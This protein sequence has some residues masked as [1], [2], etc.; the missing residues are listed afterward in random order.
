MAGDLRRTES[1]SVLKKVCIPAAIILL[2]SEAHA[3]LHVTENLRACVG[4]HLSSNTN[5]TI[6]MNLTASLPQMN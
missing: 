1:D 6:K 3:P 5:N 4:V 2:D